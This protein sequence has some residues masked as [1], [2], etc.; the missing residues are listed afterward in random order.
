MNIQYQE[1]NKKK[2]IRDLSYGDVFMFDADDDIYMLVNAQRTLDSKDCPVVSLTDG[3]EQVVSGSCDIF[4]VDYDFI[5]K[6][7]KYP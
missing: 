6:G 3:R 2:R 4:E 7:R 5:V 1:E